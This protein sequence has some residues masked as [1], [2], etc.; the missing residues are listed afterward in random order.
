MEVSQETFSAEDFESFNYEESVPITKERKL[1]VIKNS[2]HQ[3]SNVELKPVLLEKTRDVKIASSMKEEALK[4][5]EDTKKKLLQT[6][7]VFK[8]L[9]AKQEAVAK[10]VKAYNETV[11]EQRKIIINKNRTK[12]DLVALRNNRLHFYADYL[13]KY[14]LDERRCKTNND[15]VYYL[16]KKWL[17]I[18][19]LES[20]SEITSAYFKFRK[21]IKSNDNDNIQIVT[22][23][24][25]EYLCKFYVKDI[26]LE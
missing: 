2:K 5:V 14:Q 16:C 19:H 3:E 6:G 24:A 7:N 4:A 26:T 10:I 21:Q 13:F 22:S 25:H 18:T 20:K 15:F 9:Q 8:D 11:E 12:T 23:F 17:H 1:P